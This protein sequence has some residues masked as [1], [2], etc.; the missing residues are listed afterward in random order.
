M[1]RESIFTF[2][3]YVF[4]AGIATIVDIVLLFIFTEKFHIF[5]LVSACFSY[6]LGGIV[7]YLLNKRFTF[8]N[9]SKKIARQLSVFFAV[10]FIGLGLT[11]LLLFITVELFRIWYLYAKGISIALVMIWNFTG[12]KFI[13]FNVF[14]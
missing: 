10:A 3:K 9:T 12:H 14:K 2:A 13:T 1:K 11:Q 6:I 4:F 5:Y 7:H 8:K